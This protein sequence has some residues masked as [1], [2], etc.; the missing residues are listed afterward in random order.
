MSQYVIEAADNPYTEEISKDFTRIIY[1]GEFY[2][3][4]KELLDGGMSA[5]QA[6]EVCGYN[7]SKLGTKRAEMA[8]HKARNFSASDRKYDWRNY[9][10]MENLDEILKEED[11]EIMKSR[12]IAKIK[13]L[14]AMDEA[15]KKI[16]P[17]FLERYTASDPKRKQ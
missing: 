5:V 7:T 11:P 9:S 14:E 15:Q 8:A 1:T 10:G 4:M 2:L 3:K 13:V 6:Y 16:L 12:L 17:E